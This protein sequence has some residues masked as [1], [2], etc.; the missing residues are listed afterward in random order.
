M[1]S[2]KIAITMSRINELR[3]IIFDLDGT[4]CH[5]GLPISAALEE[6]FRRAGR[7]ELPLAHWAGL[8]GE[9]YRRFLRE[10]DREILEGAKY[11]SRGT[12]ALRRL[13]REVGLPQGL[14]LEIGPHFIQILSESVELSPSAERVIRALGGYRLG[15]ITNGPSRVQ[16]RKTCKLGIE[17]WFSAIIVSG[18]LGVEK[19]DEAI[20]ARMFE[21]LDVEAEEAL[22]VGDSPY[23]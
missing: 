5:Y 7:G 2:V 9:R 6:A 3:A 20:F 21:A 14:A 22:Y 4:L 12:E 18:D 13:L 15:L 17:S 8:G 11:R 1:L 19:P 10:V 16:W 23:Y